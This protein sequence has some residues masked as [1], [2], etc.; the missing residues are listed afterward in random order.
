MGSGHLPSARL[1][2]DNVVFGLADAADTVEGEAEI[3]PNHLRYS[4]WPKQL[5]GAWETHTRKVKGQ[6]CFVRAAAR[7]PTRCHT[8]ANIPCVTDNQVHAAG[9]PR[10]HKCVTVASGSSWCEARLRK[11]AACLQVAL[12]AEAIMRGVAVAYSIP[13][14]HNI[15]SR[16][17][18]PRHNIRVT[19]RHPHHHPPSPAPQH[20]IGTRCRTA[21][22]TTSHHLPR[23]H[24]T[25]TSPTVADNAISPSTAVVCT[26]LQH[27]ITGFVAMYL[28]NEWAVLVCVSHAAPDPA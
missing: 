26:A 19:S 16:C 11:S 10:R 14:H 22:N 4:K 13:Q 24:R 2:H 9:G 20:H 15:T 8:H 21:S 28:G 18:T 23:P 27:H 7:A 6:G 12:A 25:T 3:L 5:C 17:V 1:H